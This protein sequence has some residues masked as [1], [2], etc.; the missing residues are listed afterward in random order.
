M[1]SIKEIRMEYIVNKLTSDRLADDSIFTAEMQ[2]TVDATKAKLM[3]LLA[4]YRVPKEVVDIWDSEVA[5]IKKDAAIW[6]TYFHNTS[7]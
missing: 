2:E 4:S 6:F 7:L 3:D 1:R 5:L